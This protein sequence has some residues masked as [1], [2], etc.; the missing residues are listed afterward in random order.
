[1]DWTVDSV[2]RTHP[3]SCVLLYGLRIAHA[4]SIRPASVQHPPLDLELE[5]GP[6]LDL[7]LG[8]ELELELELGLERS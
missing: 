8:L 4:S 3:A 5:L 7:E 2:S 1:M 6:E